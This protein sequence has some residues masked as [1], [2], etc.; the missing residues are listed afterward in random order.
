MLGYEVVPYE[1]SREQN[2]ATETMNGQQARDY[3]QAHNLI[4]AT[5][6]KDADAKVLVHCGYAHLLET[7]SSNWT[8][9]AHYL[10]EATGLDPLTVDQTRFSERGTERAEHG[11]RI[12]AETRGLIQDRPVV[13]T[14]AA[15][16]LLRREDDSVDIR[17][18]NP[19]TQYV[20]GR[21]AWMQMGGRRAAVAIDTPECADEACIVAAFDVGWGE[22]AVPFDR[23]EVAAASVD[24]Y[25][26]AGAEVELRGYRL[27]GRA[28]FR[29][30]LTAPR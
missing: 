2:E 7:A 15:G 1:A 5:L 9:M 14:D 17:V 30:T 8:P 12:D 16:E 22:R 11:W 26:P 21:P 29:R 6:D 10:R 20:N 3:W 19:R 23:V 25:L 13:L 24:V 4:A 18:L 28:A 27:D